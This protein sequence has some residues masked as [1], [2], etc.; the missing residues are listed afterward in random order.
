VK[1][2]EQLRSRDGLEVLAV[3]QARVTWIVK[4]GGCTGVESGGGVCV[5]I[6]HDHASHPEFPSRYTR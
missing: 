2:A 3:A 6:G 4:R 5:M 1:V